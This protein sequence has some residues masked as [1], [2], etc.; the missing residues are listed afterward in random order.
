[1]AEKKDY[2]AGTDQSSTLLVALASIVAVGLSVLVARTVRDRRTLVEAAV[3]NA[4]EKA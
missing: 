1:M 3:Q 2:T 4:G